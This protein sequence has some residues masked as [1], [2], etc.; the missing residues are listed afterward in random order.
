MAPTPPRRIF[1]FRFA[2]ALL[3][4]APAAI[5]A[6]RTVDGLASRRV[7]RT[8]LAELG[9]V[10]FGV[11]NA[12]R[13]VEKILPILNG[14]IDALDLTAESRASL[15]PTV[16]KALYRLL[17]QVK[18]QMAPKPAPSQAGAPPARGAGLAGGFAAQ[19]Q[20]L[21]A[22]MMIANLRPRVPEFARVVLVELGR[23]ENKEAVKKYLAGVLAEGAKNTFSAV[24]MSEYSA[25][26]RK[27]G[28]ADAAACRVEL[29]NRIREADDRIARWY[30]T[31]LGAVALAFVLLLA[32]KRAPRWFD[33]LVLLLFCVVLLAAG[34]MSP[35]IEVEARI[36][37]LTLTFLGQPISFPEQVLY[38]QSKSVLEVFRTLI[39][40]GKPEMWV[41]GMLVLMFS[42]VFPTLKILT[43]G[44]CLGR[45]DWLRKY[46]IVRFFALESSKWSMADVMALAIFMSYV[47]FNGV[48]S[49]A[50][51]SLQAPGAQLV[52]PTDSSQILPGFYLF[53]GFVLASLFLSWKLQR[54]FVPGSESSGPRDA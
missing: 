34:I 52:I 9:H 31:A 27:Y 11:L 10:R 44:C 13:W 24:D 39:D 35:M 18:D 48:I 29:G 2:I 53:I 40:I 30:L 17:D 21:V 49:S 41:V 51:G 22:N 32:G 50:M 47:A 28:C 54:A 20:A 46:G 26:L 37:Q 36:S 4:L 43:L 25:I 6:W 5:F 38:Y 16:E 14:K 45:P 8:D 12:D 19:A 15:R 23:P 33:V 3:L 1:D 7:L 42:V